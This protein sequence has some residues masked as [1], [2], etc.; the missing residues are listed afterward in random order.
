[1]RIGHKNEIRIGDYI[2]LN[3]R[4]VRVTRVDESEGINGS[5]LEHVSWEEADSPRLDKDFFE[6]NGF[7]KRRRNGIVTYYMGNGE[8]NLEAVEREKF[9]D[10]HVKNR[11]YEFKGQVD[12][13]NHLLHAL[14][15]CSIIDEFIA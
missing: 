14:E 5:L 2:N 13:L 11:V 6:K 3:D 9:Y 7:K 4:K 1:M 8:T 12:S 15:V 10:V